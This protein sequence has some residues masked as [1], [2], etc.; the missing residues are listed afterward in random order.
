FQLAEAARPDDYQTALLMAP[1]LVTLGDPAGARAAD[2]RGLALAERRLVTHPA[3]SRALYLGASALV[4]LGR[5][6]EGLAWL[7]RVRESAPDDAVVVYAVACMLALV[8]EVDEAFAMLQRAAEIGFVH[9]QWVAADP[10]WES[11]RDD[12]RFAA[13]LESMRALRGGA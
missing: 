12:P 13:A 4:R 3:E 10:D 9:H 7:H 1:R 5:R 6:G 8:G 2:E 11:L